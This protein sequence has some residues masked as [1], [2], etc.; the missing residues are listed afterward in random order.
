DGIRDRNV[1]GVQ[2]CAL[3][4]F[5]NVPENIFGY[6][7]IMDTVNYSVWVMFMFWL[8]PFAA[9]F[10]RW[11]GAKTDHLDKIQ[12]ELENETDDRR[13]GFPQMMLLLG[14]GLLISAVSINLGEKLPELGTVINA[15]TWTITIASAVGLLLAMTPV[16][17]IAGS[18]DIANVMLYIII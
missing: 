5:L 6:V 8:V 14:L 12:V 18:L 15:T 1:T 9:K 17:K 4:I 7:L 3:P 13:I 16:S 10:N 11:T 2:T